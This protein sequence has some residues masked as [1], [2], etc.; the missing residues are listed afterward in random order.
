MTQDALTKHGAS[1]LAHRVRDFWFRKGR[2]VQVNIV[3]QP[4]PVPRPGSTDIY[5][6]RSNLVDGLPPKET[7]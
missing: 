2:K 1:V 4:P 6:V 7:A 3:Q 5:V